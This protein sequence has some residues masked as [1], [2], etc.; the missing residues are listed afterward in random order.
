MKK[1]FALVLAF[2]SAASAFNQTRLIEKTKSRMKIYLLLLIPFFQTNILF[3]QS[4]FAILGKTNLVKEG[5]AVIFAHPLL[6]FNKKDDTV[7]ISNYTFEFNGILKYPEQRRIEILETHSLTEPFFINSGIQKITI[8]SLIEP[9]DLTDIGLGI[10]VSGSVT[11]DEYFNSYLSRFKQVNK[12][13]ELYYSYLHQCDSITDIEN[14]KTCFVEA[15]SMKVKLK[16]MRDSVLFN[17]T[18]QSPDSKILPWVIND[19]I[20]Y[21]GYSNLY[22]QAFENIKN[23]IPVKI[24]LHLDSSLKKSKLTAVGSLFPLNEFINT[25]LSRNFL[26]NNKFTLIDFWFSKCRPCIAQFKLLKDVYEKN[27]EKGFGMVAISIDREID[28]PS[29]E[30]ILSQNNYPWKQILDTGGVKANEI[31]IKKY[32]SN[33]LIDN[34]GKIIAVDIGPFV[35]EDFLERNL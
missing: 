22:Q 7:K 27:N 34:T 15:N 4:R 14:Q 20:Y 5:N 2:A 8:D 1:A 33:F 12:M 16:L 35:L 32:P 25:H 17:Y 21:Y 19:A 6:S 30:K 28:I 24:K 26:Q 3:A 13:R 29:Y 9:H 18:L 31:N 10:T 11:N 23:N